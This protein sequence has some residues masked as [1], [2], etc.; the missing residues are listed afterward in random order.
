V[1]LVARQGDPAPGVTG[2]KFAAF[3]Q[4]VLPD[5][6]GP[7]F[8]ATMSG[9]K[10]GTSTGLW[11]VGADGTTRLLGQTGD[12]VDVH[13]RTEVVKSFSIFTLSPQVGGQSRDF[14]AATRVIA[15]VATFDDGTWAVLQGGAP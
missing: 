5:G 13:G 15:L 8:L 14:D 11:S 2:G 12:V 6:G 3:S 4:I 9:V 7:V 10:A 1:Q